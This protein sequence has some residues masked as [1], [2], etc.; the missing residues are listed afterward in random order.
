MKIALLTKTDASHRL[1]RL[2]DA[3]C[4]IV[5]LGNEPP[6]T[7]TV[8][9]SEANVI[10]AD[11][12]LKVGPDIINHMPGLKLIHSQGVA[13]NA[14][15][16]ET[17]RN[18]GVFVCNCA[19]A[20][21]KPVAEHAVMMMLAIL[22]SMRYNEDMVYS[23]R[24]MEA[25]TACFNVGLPELYGRKVGIVGYGAIGKALGAVLKAFGCQLCY[26]DMIKVDPA[27]DDI[28]YLPL[29]ELY[30]TSDIVSL[31]A[32]V[33]PETEHM[34]NSETLKL[35]KPGAILINTARGELM[36]QDAVAAALLS[37]Q[38]GG[39]GADTLSPEP[40]PPDNPLISGL[41]EEVRRYVV[42]S[43]H[44]AGITAGFFIRAYERIMSNIEAVGRGERPECI[45]N[46]L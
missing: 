17:A 34:V 12:I 38:L 4:T 37:G 25:K 39:F 18:A 21:A 16:L 13:F 42:L 45:V 28:E 9:A 7:E 22:K 30:A 46:G 33:T 32:P 36:D 6:A 3:G 43:P 23:D 20:N 2:S 14:I 35:F 41:P 15:D 24:Q 11:A 40:Y 44:I 8:I 31:H 19:G 27:V 1:T 26:Y 10:V 5:H 29:D